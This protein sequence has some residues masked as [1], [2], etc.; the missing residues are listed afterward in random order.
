MA[1]TLER[2]HAFNVDGTQYVVTIEQSGRLK[3]NA[4]WTVSGHNIML[5]VPKTVTS[6]ELRRILT[7]IEARIS[8]RRAYLDRRTDA[9]LE[10]RAAHLNKTY[11]DDQLAWTSLRWVTNMQHRLGS[12]TSGGLQ[13]GEIRI[14]VRIKTWPDYVLD[15]VIAHEICHRAHPDHSPAF[16]TLLSRYPQTERALGFIQGI[17]FAENGQL[18]TD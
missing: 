1:G 9:D 18:E 15:Y 6:L 8:R 10:R 4:R 12:C 3:T 7:D 16:W 2:T 5:R 17:G 14:S 11:F 13:D